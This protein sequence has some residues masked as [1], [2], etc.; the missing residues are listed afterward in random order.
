MQQCGR[1]VLSCTAVRIRVRSCLLVE[2]CCW[3]ST[4]LH[5]LEVQLVLK[6]TAHAS[7]VIA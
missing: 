2:L 1:N 4:V 3:V 5:V 7:F 6:F